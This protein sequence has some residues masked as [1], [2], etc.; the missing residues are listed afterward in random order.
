[1]CP[2]T[3]GREGLVDV[4]IIII[5]TATTIFC[6]SAF[7]Y[8]LHGIWEGR[9]IGKHLKVLTQANSQL[10]DFFEESPAHGWRTGKSGR[11]LE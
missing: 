11:G 1:M 5:T 10:P 2:G 7:C 9:M 6:S 8:V 4:F 3:L